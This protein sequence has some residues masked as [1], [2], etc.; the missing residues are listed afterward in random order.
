M[1]LT[2]TELGDFMSISTRRYAAPTPPMIFGRIVKIEYA[3]SRV[4]A[5]MDIIEICLREKIGDL[6]G[7]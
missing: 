6:M 7:N 3:R 4:G 2:F 1:K 5:P